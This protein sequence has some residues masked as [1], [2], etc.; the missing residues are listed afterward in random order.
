M[1]I[2]FIDRTGADFL[3][4][5]ALS[6][7]ESQTNAGPGMDLSTQV[8]TP[9]TLHSRVTGEKGGNTVHRV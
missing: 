9:P 2:A 7:S 5:G 1:C 6:R 4:S 8:I 3:S